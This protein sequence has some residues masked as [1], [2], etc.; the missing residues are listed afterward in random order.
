M[1]ACTALRSGCVRL[2]QS[3]SLGYD[4]N[5]ETVLNRLVEFSVANVS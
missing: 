3:M 5:V 1:R 4:I 2:T